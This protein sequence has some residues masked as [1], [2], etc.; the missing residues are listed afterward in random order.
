MRL[1][2][3]RALFCQPDL[4]MLDEPTNM[5]DVQY[6]SLPLPYLISSLK[7][8]FASKTFIRLRILFWAYLWAMMNGKRSEIR[9]GVHVDMS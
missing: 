4:L 5:L 2:L 9:R 3:A 8:T 1:A 6:P 7:V